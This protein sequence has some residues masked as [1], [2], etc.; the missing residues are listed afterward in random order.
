MQKYLYRS[1]D[2]DD[3][4]GEYRYWAISNNL[5]V[6][7]WASSKNHAYRFTQDDLHHYAVNYST[8]SG[9]YDG[10]WVSAGLDV[11]LPGEVDP[12]YVA[13]YSVYR[14]YG[15]PEEGGWWFDTG[16]LIKVVICSSRDE[17]EEVRDLLL[18]DFPATGKSQSVLGG[19]DYRIW[20]EDQFPESHFPTE[21]PHYE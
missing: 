9:I 5:R 3:E 20:F 12:V 8:P 2:V 6:G 10:T 4:T 11:T 19:E 15:G 16:E 18:V 1:E 13:V 14:V 17:A 7:K 21:Y